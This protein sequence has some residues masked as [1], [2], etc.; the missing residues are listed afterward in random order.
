[1]ML[2]TQCI[3]CIVKQAWSASILLARNDPTA[4]LDIIKQVCNDVAEDVDLDMMAPEFS[5]R[6]QSI[7][8]ARLG[9]TNPYR[10]IKE[11]NRAIAERH[12]PSLEALIDDSADRLDMAVRAAIIGNSIDLG[13][14]AD[15]DIDREIQ[16]LTTTAIDLSCLPCFQEDLG[17][18]KEILYIGDNYEEALFDRFLISELLPRTVV[19]AVRSRPVL[20]DVTLEDATRLG[21]DRLC[22]V[23]ESGSTITGT[24]L[25]ECTPEFRELFSQADVVIA[26]GQGNYETLLHETRRIYFLF[27]V[28]CDVIAE[29]SGY[30]VGSG[31]LYFHD[32]RSQ[33]NARGGQNGE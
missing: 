21:I 28:K 12:I 14:N 11:V 23:I 22:S 33:C 6:I 27:R 17:K 18:A 3:P 4:Q 26:K 8:E 15:V 1:M 19:F 24:R 31:V 25:S 9:V 13:A 7:V 20:N 30:P 32:G 16:H 10:E 29:W 2:S 5:A